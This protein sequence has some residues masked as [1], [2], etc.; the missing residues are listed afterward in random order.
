MGV[1]HEFGGAALARTALEILEDE[2]SPPAPAAGVADE[3]VLHLIAGAVRS[4]GDASDSAAPD[5]PSLVVVEDDEDTG[6]LDERRGEREDRPVGA[7]TTGED[8]GAEGE[9]LHEQCVGVRSIDGGGAN[10]D[11]PPMLGE[12]RL[13]ASVD[14]T[15]PLTVPPLRL[16]A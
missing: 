12:G 3:E 11:H 16:A 13:G 8:R 7:G 9:V 14:R 2:A 10:R 1:E 4:I 6:G 5:G 15:G